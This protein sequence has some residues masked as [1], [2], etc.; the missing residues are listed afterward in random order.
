M[1]VT[2]CSSKD[3]DP[4][5]EVVSQNPVEHV[6]QGEHQREH[7]STIVEHQHSVQAVPC[8]TYGYVDIIRGDRQLW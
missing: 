3:H 1:D 6:E 5:E 2:V 7:P 8:C 4:G